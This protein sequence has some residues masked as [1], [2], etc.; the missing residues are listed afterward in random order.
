[1]HLGLCQSLGS[2]GVFKGLKE[3]DGYFNNLME[4]LWVF[5]V[6]L[7]SDGVFRNQMESLG[8]RWSL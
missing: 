6:L 4:S 7:E 5:R 3:S 1:M 8:I 2:I